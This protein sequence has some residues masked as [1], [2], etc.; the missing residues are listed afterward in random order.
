MVRGRCSGVRPDQPL[1]PFHPT[2]VAVTKPAGST[3]TRGS[4]RRSTRALP[5]ARGGWPG[6]D[7]DERQ[8]ARRKTGRKDG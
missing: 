7:G 6:A 3:P 8:G 5:T 1:S 2:L 4:P